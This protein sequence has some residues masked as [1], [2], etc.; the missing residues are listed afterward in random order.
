[1][2]HYLID[3]AVEDLSLFPEGETRPISGPLLKK[4]LEKLVRFETLLNHFEKK[5]VPAEILRACLADQVLEKEIFRDQAKVRQLANKIQNYFQAYL[6]SC[7]I[8][9]TLEADEEHQAHQI[10]CRVRRNGGAIRCLVN[11][12]LVVSPEF[13]EL[14]SVSPVALGLGSPPYRVVENQP[15]G[16]DKPSKKS[17]QKEEVQSFV[18]VDVLL[19]KVLEMGK[20]G[21]NIQRYKG[22]GEMNPDQLWETTM[23]PATRHTLQVILEDTV[24]ADEIFT[25]L[26]GDVVESRRNFIQKHALEVKN[27][28][29]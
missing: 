13:R 20:R 18:T 29:I 5:Q 15:L 9:L 23:N 12:D 28:D 16:E 22:L 17:I 1:M 7:Q 19:S 4:L 26:M 6:P 3:L 27:L 14:A 2:K 24:I 11:Q 10:L 25:V 21:L 8:D